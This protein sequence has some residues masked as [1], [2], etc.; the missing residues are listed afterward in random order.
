[1]KSTRKMKRAQGAISIFLIIVL[2]T[3]TLLGGLMIDATRILMAKRQIRNA[4]NSSA[5]SA[6]SYYDAHMA[7]EYGMFAVKDDTAKEAFRRYFKANLALSQNSGFDIMHMS[8]KDENIT[9]TISQPLM[10]KKQ[11]L[12]QMEEYSK[13]RAWVDVGLKVTDKLKGIFSKNSRGDK[14]LSVARQSKT[15]ADALKSE[16]K[17]LSSSARNTISTAVSTQTTNAKNALNSFFRDPDKKTTAP[18]DEDLGFDKIETQISDAEQTCQEM[19][20]GTDGALDRYEKANAKS[21][22]EINS[23]PAAKGNYFDEGSKSNKT[24]IGD[25]SRI[26]SD[27][28]DT[29][30]N[31][32]LAEQ[33]KAEQNDVQ[34]KVSATRQ[35]FEDNK[36]KIRDG[37]AKVANYNVTLETLEAQKTSQST[38]VTT[39]NNEKK[40][41]ESRKNAA[42]YDFTSSALSSDTDLQELLDKYK[43]ELD[44][45]EEM[46][47][48]GDF[49]ALEAQQELAV[50]AK[51]ELD[52]YIKSLV[53][54]PEHVL[55]AQI[56]SKT[57]EYNSAKATLDSIKNSITENEKLRDNLLSD[58]E[59]W[60]G[61]IAA[62]T[63]TANELKLPDAISEKDDQ[64]KE[65]ESLG[66]I[67]KIVD[68]FAK[69]TSEMKKTAGNVN[70]TSSSK[71]TFELDVSKDLWGLVDRLLERGTGITTLVTDPG[72]AEAAF[73]FT[74]YCY[75][76]FS[77]LTS[78]TPRNNHYFQA[79]ELEYILTGE[80]SQ[81]KAI[82]ATVMDIAML[83]LTINFIDYF[84]TSTNP[85]MI[86][87]VVIAL[88]RAA[89]RTIIDLGSLIFTTDPKE[90]ASCDLCPSISKVKLTYSDHLWLAMALQALN[91]ENRDAML[92]RVI[93]LINDTYT[94]QSWGNPRDL[95]T[96]LHG[97]VTVD[98]D[99]VMLTLPMF[100]AVLPKDNPILQDGKFL[101]HASVDMG[102]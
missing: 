45:L 88:G 57:A 34:A 48:R 99:L 79:G 13:Y 47:K 53:P 71:F 91:P 56:N 9:A 80:T 35:R 49:F 38:L 68:A 42:P 2:F 90:S 10:D 31:P 15:D 29:L 74:D 20:N 22:A 65:A 73:L 64:A 95:Q 41:L 30:N 8:V 60:Y 94:Y 98:V 43:V 81:V 33:A 16:I 100:E 82:S 32:S 83:R 19:S 44:K 39:L 6:L 102:Y 75:N 96:H 36:K 66:F 72:Q 17:N 51:K 62:D 85:E 25:D 46:P 27:S 18:S 52:D 55:D 69:V 11:L 24:E 1:M 3:T 89:V 93:T 77:F 12:D 26:G 86:S 59:K 58:I 28:D 78:Q 92:D 63:S 23:A 61:E 67:A 5:R 84:A 101:V 37:A 7:S 4:L 97:E 21:A 40:S 70:K 54:P 50:A 87:R 76:T 14:S